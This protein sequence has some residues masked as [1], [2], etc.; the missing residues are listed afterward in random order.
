MG[1]VMPGGMMRRHSDG[2]SFR[3][4]PPVYSR[5]RKIV[6]LANSSKN[7]ERCIAGIDLSTRRW[8]RPID[9]NTHEGEVRSSL[10]RII[11]DNAEH[12]LKLL[13]VF[14]ANLDDDGESYGFQI[15]NRWI[16]NGSWVFSGR[17]SVK[18][19]KPFVSHARS[20]LHSDKRYWSHDELC[21]LA[22]DEKCSLQLVETKYFECKLDSKRN[23]PDWRADL[24]TT[25]GI[26]M[27]NLPLR[28]PVFVSKLESG[29]QPSNHCYLSLSFT[30]PWVKEEGSSKNCTKLIVG[31]I[32][33][34]DSMVDDT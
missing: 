14:K 4:Y 33:I 28:D 21:K 9:R 11:R 3:V 24:K 1:N 13:D 26:S 34:Q 8:V 5:I 22:Q 16:N 31:V 19:L 23:Y 17:M 25:I 10:C 7:G 32:E 6:C 29:L 20:P 30:M 12:D 2:V 27:Y 15:E 18:D